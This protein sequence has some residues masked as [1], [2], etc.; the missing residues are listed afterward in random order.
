[1]S[2]KIKI[3][4]TT[5]LIEKS[6]QALPLGAACVASSVKHDPLTKDITDVHL[7]PFNKEDSEYI[8]NSCTEEDGASYM[9]QKLMAL[10]PSIV[11][12]SVFVWNR[13][14][15]EKAAAILQ[16]NGIKTLCGGPE[17]TADPA[18]F[19]AFDK[20]C[21]GEGEYKIPLL[22]YELITGKASQVQGDKNSNTEKEYD[23]QNLESP[24]LDG[25]LDP[26]EFEGALW[27]LA[28]GCPFKCSYC[29]E[30]KGEKKV[31]MFPMERIEKELELFAKKR[32]LRFLYW[33]LHIMQTKIVPWN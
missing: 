24:Y 12:F 22:I 27:E 15:L 14:V 26:S 19:K 20:V 18:S 2:E 10:K 3:I 30:S 17:V 1:M 9:A 29:Y 32:F 8:K 25:T 23:Y 28:R 11:A 33:T 13:T 31:R 21:S 4:F 16:S 6:P 5:L 7:V